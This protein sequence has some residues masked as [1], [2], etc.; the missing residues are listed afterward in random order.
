[1]EVECLVNKINKFFMKNNK[2]I[3]VLLLT[4]LLFAVYKM[5]DY[6]NSI[7]T[8]DILQFNHARVELDNLGQKYRNLKN[9]NNLSSNNLNIII[10]ESTDNL[11]C[12]ENSMIS[13]D[14]E[15][16]DAKNVISNIWISFWP[17]QQ[18]L[19]TNKNVISDKNSKKLDEI[20]VT[21]TELESKVYGN[22]EIGPVIVKFGLKRETIDSLNQLI[23]TLRGQ[24]GE[25]K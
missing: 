4:M 1:M 6:Y 22:E 24:I 18:T 15:T 21:I 8:V 5:H 14:S 20:F 16:R 2:F 10:N 11:Y 23:N 7:Y 3:L 19:R 12:M 13:I 25:I 17:L 9:T